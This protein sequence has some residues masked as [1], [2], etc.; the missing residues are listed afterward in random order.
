M[1]FLAISKMELFP[2]EQL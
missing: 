2:E 1:R